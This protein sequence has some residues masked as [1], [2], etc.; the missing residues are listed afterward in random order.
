MGDCPLEGLRCL[1]STQK[2]FKRNG[3]LSNT[4]RLLDTAPSCRSKYP[5]YISGFVFLLF[6]VD[7]PYPSVAAQGEQRSQQG[8]PSSCFLSQT[9]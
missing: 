8:A 5:G 4:L 3:P 6:T 1:E 2:P 7:F 9:H